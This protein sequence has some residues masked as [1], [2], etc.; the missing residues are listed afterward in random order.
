MSRT[1]AH[2]SQH[3]ALP[4]NTL[5]ILLT[6]LLLTFMGS[7]ASAEAPHQAQGIELLQP[8]L[9][10]HGG[11]G[12]WQSYQSF[13]YR[14]VGFPLTPAVAEPSQSTVDLKNRHNRIESEGY[15][16]GW[17]GHQAWATPNPDAVGL[18]PRF[19]TLGS[20]YFIGMPFVFADPG[21]IL[22]QEA[23]A[24]FRGTTYKVLRARYAT[25]VGHSADDDY[26][27]YIDKQTHRLAL[28]EHSVTETGI[29][30]VTW[31]FD[32]WQEHGGL[33]L[34]AK[35]S[36]FAGPP[37]NQAP[38]AGATFTVEDARLSHEPVASG[39]YDPP[40]GAVTSGTP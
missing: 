1:T 23:D 24:T 31:T 27:I 16:V 37:A 38:E 35:M 14:L 13:E 28:I 25:G 4:L 29:E 30:R 17:N 6:M 9:E 22:E 40:A 19:Y 15:T 3:S 8:T 11:L 34:P 18:P 10:A 12:P 26:L 39:I 36:F 20:F 32:A 33:L 5:S 2:L 21:V 7:P